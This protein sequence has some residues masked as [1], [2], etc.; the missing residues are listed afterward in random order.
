M[1]E[2]DHDFPGRDA[3]ADV[4]FRFVRIAVA[5]LHFER[6]LVGAAMFRPAQR[7]DRAGDRG[8]DVR[9]GAGDRARREGRG[10][11]LVLG[12]ED[13]RG[14]HRALVRWRRLPAMQQMQEV[15]AD[16]NRRRSRR[17]SGGRG[18]RSG[19]SRAASIRA[20][21]SAGRR[22]R[23]RR[24]GCGRGP[25]AGCS[26]ARRRRFASRPSDARRRA[27]I[28]ASA[29]P[30]TAVR[31][32]PSAWP[33]SWRVPAAWA[34]CRAPGDTRSPRTRRFRRRRECRSR[35]NAGRC[36]CGRPCTARCCRRS[37]RIARPIS[38]G[39]A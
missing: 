27:A 11:E 16:R 8:I 36:R 17:R 37:R 22:C 29:A 28:P 35:D 13:Q 14:M 21:P 31:A 34:G 5:L 25:P 4:G 7:A 39:Q 19:A 30:L 6:D 33:C 38:S 9:A 18:G 23:A 1:A 26:R 20:R 12:V 2:A 3:A 32:A 15:R 24:A 10:V